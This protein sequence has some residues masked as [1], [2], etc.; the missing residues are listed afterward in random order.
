M[1]G[2]VITP[3][4]FVTVTMT[5]ETTALDAGDVAAATQEVANMTSIP[6][7]PMVLQSLVIVDPDDQKAALTAV[8]FKSNVAL[9]TEDSAPNLSDAN[10]L[11]CLGFVEIAT[12]DYKDF[13]GTS[14]ATVKNI[15]LPVIP[16][17][18]TCSIYMALMCTATPTYAGGAL[19]VHLG[20]I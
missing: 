2:S 13:G 9:G 5:M 19:T 15:G 14:V 6:N 20:F 4:H 3:A 1:S 12:T 8:F 18:D 7:Y 10:S 17:T 11:H 16:A